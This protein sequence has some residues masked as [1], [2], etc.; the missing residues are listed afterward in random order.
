MN[1]PFKQHLISVLLEL[2]RAN[3]PVF[4]TVLFKYRDNPQNRKLGRVGQTR[5]MNGSFN[6]K[7]YL[8]GGPPAYDPTEKQL[9]WVADMAL[10][11]ANRHLPREERPNPYRSIPWEG[12]E[13][14]HLDKQ[15]LT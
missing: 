1:K 14:I 12:I 15:I 3:S 2:Q 7:A 11:N 4:F 6:V 9:F 5:S 8:S 10:I 13:E